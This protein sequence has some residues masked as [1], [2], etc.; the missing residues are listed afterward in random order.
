MFTRTEVADFQLWD[1]FIT[2]IDQLVVNGDY[3]RMVSYHADMR[4]NMHTMGEFTQ[5][6]SGAISTVPTGTQRFLPWHRQYL[7]EFENLL[8]GVNP[9]LYIPYWNWA[10]NRM[11]PRELESVILD[12]TF[13]IRNRFGGIEI[14]RTR[15]MRRNSPFNAHWLPTIEDVQGAMN[16]STYI[17][18]S[19]ELE[20]RGTIDDVTGEFAPFARGAAG[21][22][23]VVHGIVGGVMGDVRFSPSD[24]IFWLHH[25]YC[26]KL[27][28]DWQVL[29]PTEGPSL[30]GQDKVLD[31]WS[32]S[33]DEI[34]D[35]GNLEYDYV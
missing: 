12:L 23:N 32:V 11:F 33:V 4:H 3:H 34:N 6:A 24:P 29:N 1:E 21:L 27:W 2:A 10:E 28:W 5:T 25:A 8:R 26:D 35:I 17:N 31:P 13:R 15:N 7:I 9:S 14:L 18:F 20:G 19:V 30:I 22:H 16:E